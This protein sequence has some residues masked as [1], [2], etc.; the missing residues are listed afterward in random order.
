MHSTLKQN[1]S[2]HPMT[3]RGKD[4]L[5]TAYLRMKREGFRHMPVLDD[6]GNL[7]GLISDRDFQ[8]AMGP[9]PETDAHGLP[10]SPKFP[11]D[12]RVVDYMSWP[13]KSLPESTELEV[14]VN[15]MIDKKIS[16][17]VVT[18]DDQMVGIITTE[19]MLK[20]LARLLKGPESVR[21]RLAVLAYNTP[22]GKAVDF[23]AVAGV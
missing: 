22:I 23:L 19:D 10:D 1:M 15:L 7:V 13:L 6:L 5:T 21:D 18:R 4:D 3:V 8:R 12:A 20:I 14:A 11:K 16:A 2:N 17:I 9:S